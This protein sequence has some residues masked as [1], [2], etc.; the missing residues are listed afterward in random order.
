MR[1]SE[2]VIHYEEA[3][4]QVHA[5]LPLPLVATRHHCR[6]CI[7]LQCV[8]SQSKQSRIVAYLSP[9]ETATESDSFCEKEHV[10]HACKAYSKIHLCI[11]IYLSVYLFNCGGHSI[12]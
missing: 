3:L 5:P 12:Q 6:L 10:I 11:L 4:Y 7:N 9:H 1:A 8:E 2:V